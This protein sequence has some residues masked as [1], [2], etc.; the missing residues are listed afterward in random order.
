MFLGEK[1]SGKTSLIYRHVNGRLPSNGVQP[2]I[3]PDLF[4]KQIRDGH[5]VARNMQIW[6]TNGT[7]SDFGYVLFRGCHCC[8]LVFDLGDRAS[9]DALD[10]WR[11]EFLIQASP[12]D[13]ANF[14]FIVVGNKSD[15]DGP[16]VVT[17]KEVLQYCTFNGALQYMQ[18]SAMEN[19]N[20]QQL[21]ETAVHSAQL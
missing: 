6:D 3:G 14:P 16:R 2:S 17:E 12:S 18:T 21:F 20:V 4:C 1:N 8:V 19:I 13:A 9:F 10:K 7:S 11:Q 15:T 5:G